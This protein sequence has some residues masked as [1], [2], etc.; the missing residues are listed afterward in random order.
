LEEK[1][2]FKNFAD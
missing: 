2:K 1:P